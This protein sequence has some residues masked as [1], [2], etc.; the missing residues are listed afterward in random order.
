MVRDKKVFKRVMK[1]LIELKVK[2]GPANF[3]DSET[4]LHIQDFCFKQTA[5]V[6]I[7]TGKNSLA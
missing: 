4:P 2:M 5:S 6:L 7:A 3:V 1:S